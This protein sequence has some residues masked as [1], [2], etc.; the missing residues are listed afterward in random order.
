MESWKLTIIALFLSAKDG[1]YILFFPL[2]FSLFGP[3]TLM[4][5]SLAKKSETLWAK[6][7]ETFPYQVNLFEEERHS[8]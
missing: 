8:N 6:K 3:K 1:L 2:I 4:P 5:G 7:T